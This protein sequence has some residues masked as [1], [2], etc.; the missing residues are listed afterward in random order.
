MLITLQSSE[1]KNR[2]ENFGKDIVSRSLDE[3]NKNK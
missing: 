2:R 1:Q 3:E